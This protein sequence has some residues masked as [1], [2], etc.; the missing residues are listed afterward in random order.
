MRTFHIGGAASRAVTVNSVEVKSGGSIRLHNIKT[1][2]NKNGNLVAV[3]RSGE[4]SLVDEFGRERERYKVPYGSV[5]SVADGDTVEGGS[6]VAT[7]DPH[8]H[9]IVT[10]VAGFAKFSDFIDGISV[11][12]T[13]DE[14]TG[15]TSL[16]VTDPKSRGSAGKDLRPMVKLVDDKGESLKLAGTDLDA[17]YFLPADAIVGLEDGA[18]SRQS[19]QSVPVPLV[20]ARTPRASS[21]S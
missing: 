4:I 16:V 19:L 11:Q 8:T 7:W 21:A 18:E 10:E 6:V 12:E 2:I 20:L 1:V 9:P 5:I 14:I 3:S 15:L 17:Q 13:T